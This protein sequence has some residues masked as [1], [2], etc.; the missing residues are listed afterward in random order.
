MNRRTR[1]LLAMTSPVALSLAAI[2][3]LFVLPPPLICRSIDCG[4]FRGGAVDVFGT[5][6]F[7]F[8]QTIVMSVGILV[9]A[10]LLASAIL[11]WRIWLTA[12]VAAF[13]LA[14]V[15]A[16]SLPSRTILP[17]PSVPCTTP[18]GPGGPPVLGQCETA[19]PPI[20]TRLGLRL[21]VVA[22]GIG[23]VVAAAAQEG[24]RPRS[25]PSASLTA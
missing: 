25:S 12:G 8:A 2:T 13:V 11:S 5:G 22:V 6:N 15:L 24:V 19:P 20:D 4:D 7:T 17:A 18:A 21:L 10:W 1:A 16:W 9:S 23:V 14:L 3:A